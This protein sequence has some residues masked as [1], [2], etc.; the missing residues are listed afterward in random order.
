METT[1]F[2]EYIQI[3]AEL[4][5]YLDKDT[6]VEGD[7][8]VSNHQRFVDISEDKKG[9]LQITPG[10]AWPYDSGRPFL[11]YK[12]TRRLDKDAEDVPGGEPE[13]L[14]KHFANYLLAWQEDFDFPSELIDD[15]ENI[16]EAELADVDIEQVDLEDVAGGVESCGSGVSIEFQ[17][18]ENTGFYY[19][20][21]YHRNDDGKPEDLCDHDYQDSLEGHELADTEKR[22]ELAAKY[23][24]WLIGE[25]NA[26]SEA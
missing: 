20:S 15:I 16:V 13:K 12:E 1:E 2:A 9:N 5:D 14:A 6:K 19:I 25:I 11:D 21:T 8:V 18:F 10:I 24:N 4:K 23:A 26:A 17:E 22:A 3:E 7:R